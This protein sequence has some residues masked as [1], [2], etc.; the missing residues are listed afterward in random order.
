M[1]QSHTYIRKGF[2]IYEELRKYLVMRRPLVIYDFATAPFWISLYMSKILFSFLSVCPNHIASKH[3][4]MQ[5]YQL[6]NVS[7]IKRKQQTEP[8]NLLCVFMIY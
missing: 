3:Y 8:Y 7:A 5:T 6:Q 2:L 1:L 4:G